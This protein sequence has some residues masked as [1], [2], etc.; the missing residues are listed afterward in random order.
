MR[1]IDAGAFGKVLSEWC[2]REFDCFKATYGA[3]PKVVSDTLRKVINML[4]DQPTLD[5]APVRHGVWS[6]Y[7]A[8]YGFP[9]L[10]GF[11]CSVCGMHQTDI[12]GLYYCPNCGAKMDGEK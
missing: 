5:Y 11:P 4:A 9:S 3:T 6:E 7:E 8:P 1:V 10:N 12:R 2:S